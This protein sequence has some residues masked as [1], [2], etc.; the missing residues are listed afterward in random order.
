MNSH[1]N[2]AASPASR[3]T[4]LTCLAIPAAILP[5]FALTVITM[6][7][8]AAP[9]SPSFDEP[10]QLAPR[11]PILSRRL[12][13]GNDVL[14]CTNGIYVS[15]RLSDAETKAIAETAPITDQLGANPLLEIR[16]SDA[17]VFYSQAQLLK[18]A[19]GPGNKRAIDSLIH[20]IYLRGDVVLQVGSNEINAREVLYNFQTNA[21]IMIDGTLRI[22]LPESNVPLYVRAKEIRQLDLNHYTARDL[23]FSTDEFYQPFFWLGAQSADIQMIPDPQTG[24]SRAKYRLDNITTNVNNLP[25]LWWPR[26]AGTGESSDAPL[27]KIHTSY[28]S[29]L[30]VAV[31]T[32]WHTGWLLGVDEPPGVDST[33]RLD[34]FT[35]HGPAVGFDLDYKQKQ[36]FGRIR[37]YLIDDNGDDQFADY[38]TREDIDPPA[39]PAAAS[40]SSIATTCPMTGSPRSN[41]ATRATPNSSKAGN[42]KNSLPIKN[43]KPSSTS[44]SNATTGPSTSSTSG[45]ST[46]S[47]TPS[48][49]YLPPASTSSART[50]STTSPTTRTATSPI[51]A[52]APATATYP[53]QPSTNPGSCPTPSMMRATPSPSAVTKSPCRCTSP[54]STSPLPS[55]ASTPTMT[56]SPTT[57][58]STAPPASAP[59][60]NCG[61]STITSAAASGTLTASATSSSPRPAS[62]LPTPTAAANPIATSS[63][64]PCVNAGKPCAAP[65]TRSIPSIG[66]AGTPR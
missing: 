36:Y 27:K 62:L 6:A 20:S 42:A 52:N 3:S 11:G 4:G 34:E 25:I 37:S 63:T 30:G 60:P 1:Y 7:A 58:S 22:V 44:S 48:P 64:S 35:K 66:S 32:E 18:S 8:A 28:D 5:L 50:S 56:P 54:A 51:S 47:T 43:P 41:W 13:D 23:K 26:A 12:P 15:K 16:A 33:F 49:N 59:R 57:A 14:I 38:P 61:T 40:A 21:G 53:A 46:T 9:E 2:P 39:R 55:S 29:Q 65:P 45:I 24:R 19:P 17:V 31:E 10:V